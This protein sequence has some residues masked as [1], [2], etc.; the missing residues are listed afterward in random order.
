MTTQT[1]VT[2]T[3]APALLPTLGRGIGQIMLQGNAWTGLLFL[4]SLIHI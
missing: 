4:L 1:P 2:P 3:A